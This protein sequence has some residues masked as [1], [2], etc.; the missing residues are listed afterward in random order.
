MDL[1]ECVNLKIFNMKNSSR[2]FIMGCGSSSMHPDLMKFLKNEYVIAV[3]QWALLVDE[4][5]FDFYF[6]ND[7]YRW[8]KPNIQNKMYDFLKTDIPKWSKTLGDGV[9]N[10]ISFF[11]KFKQDNNFGKHTYSSVPWSMRF[12]VNSE[13]LTN[14]KL[15]VDDPEQY[16]SDEYFRKIEVQRTGYGSVTRCAVDLAFRLRFKECYILNFDSIPLIGTAYNEHISRAFKH[17]LITEENI[18]NKKYYLNCGFSKPTWRTRHQV[19]NKYGMQVKR[20]IT[21]DVNDYE[22]AF[23]LGNNKKIHET[24]VKF[25]RPRRFFFE[26]CLF[27]NLIKGD[28]KPLSDVKI[29]L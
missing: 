10:E 26:T 7:N 20:V 8:R 22:T 25:F 11:N 17:Q 23:C 16:F 21:S 15:A 19:Y 24:M 5:P 14:G 29:S 13:E 2:V 6:V 4:F 12:D 18:N 9:K 28:Y 3:S 27:E 1:T